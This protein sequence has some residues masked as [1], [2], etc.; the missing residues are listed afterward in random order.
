MNKKGTERTILE[1]LLYIIV[2]AFITLALFSFLV[3]ILPLLTSPKCQN[4]ADFDQVSLLLGNID[5]NK[6]TNQEIFF[7]NNNC[8]LVSFSKQQNYNLI[9]EPSKKPNT[10][11]YLCLCNID[12]GIC[13]PYNCKGLTAISQINQEQFSTEDLG[14]YLFLTFIKEGASL[15]ITT[16]LTQLAQK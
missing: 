9:P 1:T 8:K 11:T 2:G 6:I 5:A 12:G 13:K 16:Q 7:N 4:A 10:N 3:K 15:K 14:D